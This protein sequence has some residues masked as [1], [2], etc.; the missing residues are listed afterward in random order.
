MYL[1]LIIRNVRRSAR[2][3]LIY[4]VTMTVCSMLFYSFLSV[5]SRYYHPDLGVEYHLADLGDGMKLAIGSI[6][7]LI[8]FLIR[9]VNNYMLRHRQKEFAVQSVLGM[10]QRA[11]A[12]IF[13]A[14]TFVLGAVCVLAGIFL[15]MFCS[16]FIT[17]MLLNGYGLEYRFSFMLFPDTVLLTAGFFAVSLA[18]VG[19][20]HVRTIRKIRILHMLHAERQNDA[21]LDKSRY[22]PFVT[23]L[24]GIMLG[25][26]VLS[27]LS[28]RYFYFDP[29]LPLPARIMFRGN[30][31]AP[32]LCLAWLL[33]WLIRRKKWGFQRLVFVEILFTLVSAC[34]FASVP[35]ICMRYQLSFGSSVLGSD[36]GANR[37]LPFLLADLIY[38]VCGIIYLS[39][40]FLCRWK[41]KDPAHT[42]SG[43][44]LFFFGQII[45]RLTTTARTMTLIC[46]TLTASLFLFLAVPAL[47]GWASGFLDQRSL[48]DVQISS[49]YNNV[50]DEASLLTG[51]SYVDHYALVPD[52]LAQ[53]EIAVSHDC[54]FSLY[55]PCREEFHNRVKLDFPV[56]AIRLSDYNAIREML[57]YDKIRL[58]ENEFTTQWQSIATEKERVEFM[59]DRSRVATDAGTLRLSQENPCYED[60]LGETLYNRYTDVLY[61]FP[62]RVC[63]DLLSVM[64]C[65][66]IRTASPISYADALE[67]ENAFRNVYPE[68]PPGDSGMCY[69]IRTRTLQVNDSRADI[70]MTNAMMTYGGIVLMVICL[71]ILSLQQLLDASRYRYRFGVLR[72]M[73][74]E[75][76][77]IDKLI[78]KQLC[79]WF[80][81]PVAV[82]VITALILA[83]YFFLTIWRQISAYMGAG[84]LLSQLIITVCVLA[85]LLVCYFVSTWTLFKG[86]VGKSEK[87]G[88]D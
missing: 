35:P 3:Y 70:F 85:A 8:L 43:Q 12:W 5:T 39:G 29:R 58:A 76:Q 51:D 69:Y 23:I 65:R 49:A 73:G 44:N 87:N 1:K 45:S 30:I 34:F 62:D 57:G 6:S 16:Q 56:V 19:L 37:Y 63:E 71:T 64:R 66:Y 47:T 84:A 33:V 20:F 24:Y 83:V 46:L 78:L 77:D 28:T 41:E 22:M 60:T 50:Y 31:L 75:E 18:C 67:L 26:M 80:G 81:L 10:E 61:V 36:I 11:I 21:A 25:I 72:K 55:L 82:A 14:E 68:S 54:S 38:L 13:F 48:Y 86:A 2:D 7:L 52:F 32:L 40:A 15:G 17:A 53:H 88:L 74:V 59:K 27:G 42:Y 9:F 79:V 4:M